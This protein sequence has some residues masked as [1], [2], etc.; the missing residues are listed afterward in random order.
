M[1]RLLRH[2]FLTSHRV[3]VETRPAER[4]GAR[5]NACVERAP[6]RNE[7]RRAVAVEAVEAVAHR[8]VQLVV[9]IACA[10][11]EWD[12]QRTSV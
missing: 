6:P 7:E 11:V 8:A 1:D 2:A 3:C 5:A 4:G 10:R 12:L 9:A